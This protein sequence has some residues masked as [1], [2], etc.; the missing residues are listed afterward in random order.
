MGFDGLLGDEQ[1]ASDLSI[2]PAQD[3]LGEHLVLAC[4]KRLR[5]KHQHTR[6]T[7]GLSVELTSDVG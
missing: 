2:G 3:D 5:H 7:A 4:G 6:L 1:L